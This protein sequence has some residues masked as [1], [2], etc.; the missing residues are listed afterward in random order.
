MST[1]VDLQGLNIIG[2]NGFFQEGEENVLL[3]EDTSPQVKND[4]SRRALANFDADRN[5]EIMEMLS[6]KRADHPI[7]RE[8][9]E[10]RA[11]WDFT[12]KGDKRFAG[13]QN[14]YI[15]RGTEVVMDNMLAHLVNDYF[16]SRFGQSPR[17][18]SAQQFLETVTTSNIEPFPRFAIPL[19]RRA[20][21]ELLYNSL[22]N[23]LPVPT[24][25]VKIPYL[26]RRYGQNHAGGAVIN[27]ELWPYA[28]STFDQHYGGG[29]VT[30][31][32]I[33]T[34]T[35]G[36]DTF[37]LSFGPTYAHKIYA[38]GVLLASTAYAVSVG[39]GPGG[40][41]QIVI[42]DT[43]QPRAITATYDN[44][45]EGTPGRSL[46]LSVE[47]ADLPGDTLSMSSSYTLEAAL[48]MQSYYNLT[49]LAEL[50][51]SLGDELYQQIDGIALNECL[52][53][54]TAGD[55]TFDIT[56]YLPGDTNS[57]D[58][59]AYD[60]KLFRA[61]VSASQDLFELHRRW[62]TFLV[63]GTG[64]GERLMNLEM[65]NTSPVNNNPG[66]FSID[67]RTKLLGVLGNRWMVYQNPKLPSNRGFM[68]W[69][70]TSPF[71]MGYVLTMFLP[72]FT[73]PEIWKS[74]ASG[75][76]AQGAFV[77]C[78]HHMVDPLQYST[79]TLQNA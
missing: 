67:Q 1:V 33:G 4:I 58:R 54:A 77:M 66:Q 37:N 13:G 62:P 78:G 9:P 74:D 41:D 34:T 29:R 32:S 57:S 60:E 65:F 22:F 27:N 18:R 10:R 11:R 24:L 16:P 17:I 8:D 56:G 55:S 64:F 31:E 15:R 20:I 25:D 44:R 68:G 71:H 73:T 21:P 35:A 79:V 12:F 61:L 30:G 26:K 38:G 49:M 59:K 43:L 2:L 63:C 40:V 50:M 28:G 47:L 39:T 72:L 51:N 53:Q 6:S 42:T 14:S 76:R 52:D 19:V 48:R 5:P 7:L 70:S 46:S 36:P 69:P 45:T 3:A 23:V 75:E